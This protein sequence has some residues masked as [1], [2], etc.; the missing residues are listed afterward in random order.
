MNLL[1]YLHRASKKEKYVLT[2]K[3]WQDPFLSIKSQVAEYV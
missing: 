2:E 3:E 1:K